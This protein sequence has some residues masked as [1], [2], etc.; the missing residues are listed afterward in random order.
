MLLQVDTGY[1]CAGVVVNGDDIVVDAAPIFRWMKGKAWSSVKHWRK[2]RSVTRV[3]ERADP[4]PKR[5]P[6][7]GM[8]PIGK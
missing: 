7:P 6:T 1:A 8:I 4:Y 5:G 3:P 2:I